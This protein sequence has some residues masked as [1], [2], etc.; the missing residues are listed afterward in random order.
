M[1]NFFK[2]RKGDEGKWRKVSALAPG[3]EI[4]VPSK[5]GNLAWDKIVSIQTCREGTGLRY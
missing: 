4:A 1:F 2:K 3:M 5:T